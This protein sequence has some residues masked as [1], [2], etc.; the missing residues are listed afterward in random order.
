MSADRYSLLDFDPYTLY[1]QLTGHSQ[2]STT[3]SRETRQT[4]GS[5][6][7][8]KPLPDPATSGRM[9]TMER[10]L[11]SELFFED[12]AVNTQASLPLPHLQPPS[13]GSSG[14]ASAGRRRYQRSTTLRRAEQAVLALSSVAGSG[15]QDPPP[16]T[17]IEQAEPVVGNHDG[18]CHFSAQKFF[19]TDD[20]GRTST[21]HKKLI[22]GSTIT[23]I[24]GRSGGHHWA[25]RH[26]QPNIHTERGER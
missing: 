19:Q 12:K 4:R 8:V 25:N 7:P 5:W 16:A 23:R 18:F 10:T 24:H 14:F 9:S 15:R 6:A 17:R 2:Y 11:S 21:V 22:C 26:R 20:F 1:K 13:I 3:V